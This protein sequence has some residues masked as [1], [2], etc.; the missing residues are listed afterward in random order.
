MKRVFWNLRKIYDGKEKTVQRRIWTVFYIYDPSVFIAPSLLQ[1]TLMNVQFR[2]NR[3][4][5]F[6]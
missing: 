2:K 3:N 1:I 6:L 4:L 5:V